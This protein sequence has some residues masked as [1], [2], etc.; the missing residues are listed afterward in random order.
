MSRILFLEDDILLSQ[1]ICEYLE[2]EG[3]E[4]VHCSNASSALNTAYDCKFDLW[5]FDVKVP[6]GE[7][8]YCLEQLPGFV[9]LQELRK[10]DKQTPCI[11]ATSLSSI[12]DLSN[13]YNIGCDDYIKKPFELVELKYRISTLIKRSYHTN[14]EYEDIGDGL[15]FY[16]VSKMLYKNDEVVCLT[17]KELLL[18]SLLIKNANSYVTLDVIFNEVWEY[19]KEP[20]ELS[21]RAYIKNLRKVIG[22]SRILNQHSNGYCY[23]K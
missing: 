12:D 6:N 13:G 1:I 21:L 18:L 15:R 11:F 17:K 23:V 7:E 14:T 5:L 22:K 10:F 16:F 2:E 20:S 3:F 9:L 8:F 4:V 19:D